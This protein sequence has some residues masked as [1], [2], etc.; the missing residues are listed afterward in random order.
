VFISSALQCECVARSKS[1][2]SPS[3]HRRER[4]AGENRYPRT[5]AV[6]SACR[7]E[8]FE[9]DCLPSL[10]SGVPEGTIRAIKVGRHVR[11]TEEQIA[12]ALQALEIT[13]RPEPRRGVTEA[14][15]RRRRSEMVL[16]QFGSKVARK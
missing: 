1:A 9:T 4:P 8:C 13:R 3:H 10:L 12:D 5:P 15:L 11:M 16:R 2:D 7:S 6:K 14:S